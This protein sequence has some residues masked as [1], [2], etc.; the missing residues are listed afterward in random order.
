MIEERLAA[1][2]SDQ[3]AYKILDRVK[4]VDILQLVKSELV[5]SCGFTSPHSKVLDASTM[6]RQ[7]ILRWLGDIGGLFDDV[8]VIWPFATFSIEMKYKDFVSH[9][10]DL[11]YP[12]SDDV[13]VLSC[14]TG[15]LLVIDHEEMF[16]LGETGLGTEPQTEPH[17]VRGEKP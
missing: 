2:R 3:C 12:S 9:F 4:C 16:S 11:W 5:G 14:D 10:D 17:R 6:G 13:L 8:L 7:E 15:W 1:L